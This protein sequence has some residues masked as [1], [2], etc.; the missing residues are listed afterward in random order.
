[1]LLIM[2]SQVPDFG[3]YSRRVQH[4]LETAYG[5]RI[6]TRDI[7]DPLTGDLNGAEI[8]IDHAVTPEQRLFLLGHLFG[9]TVQWNTDPAAYELGQPRNAPIAGSLIPALMEYEVIA[10]QYALQLF[11]EAGVTGLDQW[12]ADYTACDRAYLG[13]YYRTGHRRSFHSFW[14][15]GTARIQPVAIPEFQLLTRAFRTDG[16]VI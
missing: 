16:V 1:M 13:N 8:H 14:Q 7:P 6:V 2:G 3:E 9:H 12:L 11:H 4:R 15:D 10:G 5:I